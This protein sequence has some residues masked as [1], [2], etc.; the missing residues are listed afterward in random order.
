MR[1]LWKEILITRLYPKGVDQTWNVA[2]QRQNDIKDKRPA[3]SFSQQYAKWG[4]NNSENDSPETHTNSL[5]AK[6]L[7]IV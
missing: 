4:Q 2:Q 6:K 5:Q 3:E 7:I 1:R